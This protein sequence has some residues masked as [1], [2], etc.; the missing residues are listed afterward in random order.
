MIR[1]KYILLNHLKS[2]VMHDKKKLLLLRIKLIFYFELF[3]CDHTTPKST[4]SHLVS[5]GMSR[6]DWAYL[7][8]L[9]SS[10]TIFHIIFPWLISLCK[11]SKM[12]VVSYLRYWWSKNLV[13]LLV[14]KH[15]L[16]HTLN[17]LNLNDEKILSFP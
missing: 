14:E 7:V 1:G 16:L 4:N 10:S 2:Y 12:L 6:F 11:K 13:V 9:T 8:H 15:I 3:L 17:Y 5:L